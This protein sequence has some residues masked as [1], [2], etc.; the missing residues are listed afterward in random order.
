MKMKVV[1]VTEAEYNTWLKTQTKLVDMSTP[2]AP[3][4]DAQAAM[5][6]KNLTVLN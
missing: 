2:A 1:V 4:T 5:V 6:Q 3:T